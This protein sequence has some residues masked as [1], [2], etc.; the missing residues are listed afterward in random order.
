VPL[1]G[2]EGEVP[3]LMT[4]GLSDHEIAAE[5]VVSQETVNTHVGNVPAKRRA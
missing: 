1:T 4:R 5:L 3:R 2:H